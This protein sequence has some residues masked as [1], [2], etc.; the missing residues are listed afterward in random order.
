[1]RNIW[2]LGIFVGILLG[3]GGF[4]L[5]AT[6]ARY[7][8]PRIE[9]RQ[10]IFSNYQDA[11]RFLR[12]YS[13]LPIAIPTEDEF[14]NVMKEYAVYYVK[15]VNKRSFQVSFDKDQDCMGSP[16]CFLAE[17]SAEKN[18]QNVSLLGKQ[19][20]YITVDLAKGIKGYM[21]GRS[22]LFVNRF[23]PKKLYWQVCGVI[24]LLRLNKGTKQRYIDFSEVLLNKTS[25]KRCSSFLRR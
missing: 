2:Q 20:N 21:Q 16:S 5:P 17:F 22:S 7:K 8:S 10:Q 23:N 19:K 24:Y 13:K 9:Q 11:Y 25:T 6:A 14:K 12:R 1:M 3:I 18:K 15:S 4:V